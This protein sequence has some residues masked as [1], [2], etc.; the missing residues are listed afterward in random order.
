MI[1]VKI[2][3]VTELKTTSCIITY[4]KTAKIAV[5]DQREPN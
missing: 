2:F 4:R 5:Y 1:D 3:N